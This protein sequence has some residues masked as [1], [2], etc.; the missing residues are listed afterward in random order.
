LFAAGKIGQ[1]PWLRC[2]PL[3]VTRPAVG[4]RHGR[5]RRLN[6][7]IGGRRGK[8]RELNMFR[9]NIMAPGVTE[10]APARDRLSLIPSLVW[11]KP[12]FLSAIANGRR[13]G[14]AAFGARRGSWLPFDK[15]RSTAEATCATVFGS[16]FRQR[17]SS[18]ATS[19]RNWA[20][21]HSGRVAAAV[22]RAASSWSSKPI[23]GKRLSCFK[24]V[25]L[26]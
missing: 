18:R 16:I 25:W 21:C 14:H 9:D 11:P 26:W 1:F 8:G 15:R 24:T 2:A 4:R 3:Q 23:G 10:R 5:H 7:K 22:R 17:P 6:G 13:A 19:L 12:C 20:R